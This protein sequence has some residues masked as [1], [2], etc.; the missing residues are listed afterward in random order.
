MNFLLDTDVIIDFQKKKNPGFTYFQ[1][2]VKKGA[3]LSVISYSEII[4]GMQQFSNKQ[5]LINEFESMLED[6]AVS[7]LP[8]DKQIGNKYAQ[9]K[10]YL[11]NNKNLLPDFDIVIAASA[12]SNDLTLITRNIKHFSRIPNLQLFKQ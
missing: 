5:K 12:I 4:L 8:I 3:S 11:Q 7:V 1:T 2:A 10:Y 6:F 9:L